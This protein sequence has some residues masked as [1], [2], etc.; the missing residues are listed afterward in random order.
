MKLDNN[1]VDFIQHHA[2]M[3]G[4]TREEYVAHFLSER[5]ENKILTFDEFI[6]EKFSNLQ[7]AL[8]LEGGAAGHMSHPFDEKDL[9]FA[10]FKTIVKSGLQGELNFE[11]V[12]TEKTDGQ[13]L[14]ATVRNGITLFSRNKGQ[15]ISP[16]DL[17]GIIK[18]FEEHEVPLVRETYVFAAKDLNEALPK[19]KD[20]SIFNEGKNFINMEL[21]YSKNPN[22]IYYERDVLQFHDIKET[23][24]NGNIIGE[25]KIAGELVS[26]LK[27]VD[28]D[29]QKT[30][31][32]I[33]PQILKLGRDINFEKNHAKFIK[34]IEALRDRYNLTDGDE[35]SRYHEMWW[36]ETI[37]EN[38]PNL[39]QDY[40][41]GLLLR[42]AYG[43]KKSLNMRSLAKE[44][45]E[46][47]AA[48]VKKFDKEDVKKKYKENIR[49]FEDLFLE[50]GS[51]ILKNASNFVAAN[52]D[53]EM[54]RLHNQIR[55]EA[56]KIKKGGSVAQIEKV[57]KELERLDR[58]G[59]VESIIPTE[60]IVFVYK[61]K[62]MKLTGTFA[63]INQL[64][65]VIKYGR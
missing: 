30:F 52:P 45:G 39:Q 25:Q 24:G 48:S 14:F 65:G 47:E 50:L 59:G 42:W 56:D 33:P 8:I 63:A 17:A 18:M 11:E 35:V 54:Q 20:Q 10:D 43:D 5:Y 9:T 36:R 28:A 44:I 51:I 19:I 31:T 55:T 58:I 38:F 16:V 64:M 1:F 6:V 41:E 2:D 37:D 34:Q 7:E 57:M 40:K 13:N 3:Q 49:P 53:K 27:E 23:D 61:G 32:I 15:L 60:G 12:A 29:V 21:I 22:V 4:M 26:A 46:D 62:T